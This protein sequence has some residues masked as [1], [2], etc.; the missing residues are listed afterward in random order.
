MDRV[1]L[2]IA[3]FSEAYGCRRTKIYELINSGDLQT[4]KI[5]RRTLITV[6]SATA[7]AKRVTVGGE[8]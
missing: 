2:S 3:N 1:F 7:F 6:E 5:G 8:R 4:A